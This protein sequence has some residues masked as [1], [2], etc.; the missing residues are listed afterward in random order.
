MG[1][2]ASGE[3]F[4]T[5]WCP[6]TDMTCFKSADWMTGTITGLNPRNCNIERVILLRL[7]VPESFWTA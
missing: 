2:G 6:G 4:W 5:D 7:G 3:L 1:V